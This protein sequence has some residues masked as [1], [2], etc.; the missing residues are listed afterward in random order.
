MAQEKHAP[1][2]ILYPQDV[3]LNE[4]SSKQVD[5]SLNNRY[6]KCDNVKVNFPAPYQAMN[7]SLALMTWRVLKEQEIGRAHV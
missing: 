5:F 4:I 1:L 2:A 6:Y 3:K 7:C